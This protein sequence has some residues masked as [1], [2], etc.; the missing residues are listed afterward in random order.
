MEH[1]MTIDEAAKRAEELRTRLNQWSREYYVEDKPT[2]ED[3]VY[4]KEY[5]ELVAIEE[6]YPDLITSDSPTQRV[7]GKVLEGFEKVTHDIPLYSLNDVFS[8]EELIAFDQRVQ[9]AVGRVV[10]YCCELKI[11][12]LSVSLRYEDGNFVRGATRG[13]GTVGENITENL[14]TVRSV[15]IKL[16]EPMNIEV[17]GE[18]FMPKRSFVQLNQDR[19]AEGKDIFANPRNAAAGSLRQLDSKITAKRN[20]DTFLYTVADFGPMQAKT[21]YDAL[22]ELEKI[23][24]HTNREKRLCHSIDEVWS[25]IEEYHDKRVDLPYE[26]DGIVIKVN[27]FSL[28]DQL[29]FTVKAPRWA[30]A[31]KFPPEEVETLIENIEWTVGRTGVVTPTAIMTP[32]R[33]AGTTVSRASLHNGDYIKLKDIRLKDTVLIYKAGDIIPEVSQVVLDKRPKDS[34]EY[35]LPTHCPV[36]GSE[37]V[38]L[39]EEVALRCINPKCP[40]Q[41]KEGL[42][43]FVSRNAMNIDG[44]GPRVLEQMYDKKLVADVADLYKLTEEEL[45]TLDKI[46]EK[47]ANIILTAID[48]SKD[49]SVERLI[50]GLGIRHVGAKAAKILA[51]HF[52]D[53]E[54]LSKSDYESIIALDTIGDIIADSVVTYFSNEEVHELMNELKQAGVNF[55]YKGLRNAQLQ[56]VESPFKEKTV[57]LT[58]K[59]TRFTREEAKETI[60]NLGGKVT[61]SVSK[62][63]D[64]VVA[65]EDAGSKLT[66]AQ[67]LGIEVWTEDQMADALAKSRSVEE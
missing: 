56:E 40:A 17:R 49:N 61:G 66:K 29:G 5:A 45:L 37:L 64:I 18:C 16:K 13:D 20:L 22:E 11:D 35:Q 55:E 50:F 44:L 30:A 57:V 15:P 12:G 53:L 24:F 46:K 48:N 28:Q 23:G 58:G 63:T 4:D 25:Y 36:C 67:E 33:V 21:Q 32:V 43:H 59:L 9:K 31:Y 62:K 60:E 14:K 47:S 26:I 42:N 52:G 1:E 10:D 51:E 3:Y 27:E 2:V 41:M 8:K 19:E 39:D 54:T 7:G 34:E 38:H 65:G 6:Q